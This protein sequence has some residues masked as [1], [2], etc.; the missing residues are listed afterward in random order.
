MIVKKEKTSLLAL[1]WEGWGIFSVFYV[2]VSCRLE[3]PSSGVK[4]CWFLLHLLIAVPIVYSKQGPG[5]PSQRS[6]V[7]AI[8]EVTT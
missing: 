1:F 7:W 2:R 8:M 6:V 4:S 5:L 3:R